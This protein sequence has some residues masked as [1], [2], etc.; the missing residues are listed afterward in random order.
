MILAILKTANNQ[1]DTSEKMSD[2]EAINMIRRD[3]FLPLSSGDV[4]ISIGH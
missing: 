4:S 1:G 2:K 3:T